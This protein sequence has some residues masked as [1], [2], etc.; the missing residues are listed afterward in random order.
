MHE[1][2]LVLRSISCIM[3]DT[4]DCVDGDLRLMGG[5]SENE[6]VLQVCFNK[7]W[8]TVNGDG[9]TDEDTQVTCRQLGF[10]TEGKIILRLERTKPL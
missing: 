5:D 6:G 3:S 10:N 4:V 2:V 7:R 8:G 9:W 1:H